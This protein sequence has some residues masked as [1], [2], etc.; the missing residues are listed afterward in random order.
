M[1]VDTCSPFRPP[2]AN[3]QVTG[4]KPFGAFVNVGA[5]QD[6]LLQ[7]WLVAWYEHGDITHTYMCVYICT[8]D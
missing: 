1:P 7:A 6:G 8:T 3:R 5:E 2:A 4:V